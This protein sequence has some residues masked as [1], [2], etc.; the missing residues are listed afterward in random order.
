MLAVG[1]QLPAELADLVVDAALLAED[2]SAEAQEVCREK[3]SRDHN[4][5]RTCR[6][7]LHSIVTQ[8]CEKSMNPLLYTL[9][10]VVETNSFRTGAGT[11]PDSDN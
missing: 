4:D 6:A 11:D 3:K 7:R 1:R 9:S 10:D 8:G 5:A 2:H